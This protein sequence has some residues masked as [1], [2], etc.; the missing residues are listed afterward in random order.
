MSMCSTVTPQ[1][2]VLAPSQSQKFS[3]DKVIVGCIRGGQEDEYRS[4]VENFA[5]WCKLDQLQL[6]IRKTK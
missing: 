5:E 6:N 2:T 1:G 3:D 4:L